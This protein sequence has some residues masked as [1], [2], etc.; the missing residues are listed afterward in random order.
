[1][2]GKKKKPAGKPPSK[3]ERAA[4][5]AKRQAPESKSK[6][7][8]PSTAHSDKRPERLHSLEGQAVGERN[9]WDPPRLH[10]VYTETFPA[11]SCIAIFEDKD[12]PGEF[13]YGVAGSTDAQL[14]LWTG[15]PTRQAAYRAG[16]L[17]RRKTAR[18]RRRGG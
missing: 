5:R 6:S 3:I 15:Y 7:N 9:A 14:E 10:R 12:R 4:A 18:Q 13:A 16:R 17:H 2:S 1:M 11:G 8:L